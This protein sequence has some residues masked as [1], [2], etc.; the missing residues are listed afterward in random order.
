MSIARAKPYF[1]ITWVVG[2]LSGED[3][4]E[5]KVWFKAHYQNY[6]K[7]DRNLAEWEIAHTALLNQLEA[8]F[9]VDSE[10]VYKEVK[11]FIKGR[12]A[13][14]SGKM[15]L[16]VLSP[17]VVVDAKTGQ[18]KSSHAVQVKLYLLAIEMGGV[19]QVLD[20]KE[21][22]FKGLL[23]YKDGKE[24]PVAPPDEE[25][26]KSFF[27][28]IKRLADDR[29]PRTTPSEHECRFC[30]IKGCKDRFVSVAPVETEFF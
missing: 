26:N 21:G 18:K 17:N 23:A 3:L 29:K 14:V 13:D 8:E 15:D 22:P 19:A 28:L 12:V 10:K 7:L 6:E 27:N 1:W 9:K 16:L 25:F 30:D 11:F 5:W 24:V 4:C 2:L 20:G